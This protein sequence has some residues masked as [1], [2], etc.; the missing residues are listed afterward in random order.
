VKKSI[1]LHME[2]QKP[3]TWRFGRQDRRIRRLPPLVVLRRGVATLYG[4]LALQGG[5]VY[6]FFLK[7][8]I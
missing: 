4:I 2:Q 6:G 3:K 8:C 1:R 7:A 5:V